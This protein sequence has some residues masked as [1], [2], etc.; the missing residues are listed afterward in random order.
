MG[1]LVW[2][3]P[4]AAGFFSKGD[5]CQ[6]C[7]VGPA[8]AEFLKP[9][10]HNKSR[11]QYA[12]DVHALWATHVEV[13]PIAAANGG[14]EPDSFHERLAAE[15]IAGWARFRDVIA[16]GLRDGHFLKNFVHQKHA[17]AL[18]DGFFH[19]QKNLFEAEGNLKKALNHQGSS[20][21]PPPD[22][23]SSWPQMQDLPEYN[24]LRNIIEVLSRRYLVRSGMPEADAKKLDYSIFNWA[25]VH[26]PGEFHGPHTHVGEYH[27]GVFYA[28]A[29]GRAGK[30]RLGDPRGQNSPFGKQFM[31]TPRSGDLVMF[32]SWL[33]HMATVSAPGVSKERVAEGKDEPY[34]VVF[35]FNI[36]PIQGPLPCHLWFS[37][38]TSQMGFSRKS[39]INPAE[40]G[41]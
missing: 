18:N 26:G 36:G 9:D 19:F 37:D 31:H 32:P 6:H 28:Q 10:G 1:A 21:T 38:P 22:A 39:P 5:E 20:P 41:L 3:A 29:G 33:S 16:P 40:L 13:I 34:R 2:S 17:G 27:V 7:R 11:G 8:F 14:F 15:A 12:S 24:R 25:A 35:S 23:N 30:L 4:L